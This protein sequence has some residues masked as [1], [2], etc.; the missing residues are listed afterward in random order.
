MNKLAVKQIKEGDYQNSLLFEPDNLPC[1]SIDEFPTGIYTIKDVGNMFQTIVLYTPF[2]LKEKYVDLTDGT[3]GKV[4]KKLENFFSEPIKQKY[5]E[6]GI[7][8]KTGLVIY[9]PPGTGKTV[10]TFIIMN[11]IIAKYDAICLA[12]TQD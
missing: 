2:E 6:L 9:G 4:M 3:V 7:A 10:T 8:H 12:M 5:E 11:K 1:K